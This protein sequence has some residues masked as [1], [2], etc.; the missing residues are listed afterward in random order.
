MA[1]I[2]MFT[3]FP[4]LPPE[5]RDQIWYHALSGPRQPGICQWQPGLWYTKR[6]TAEDHDWSKDDPNNIRLEF[7]YDRLGTRVCIPI[8]DVNQEAHR[9]A[10]AW[11]GDNNIEK[12]SKYGKFKFGRR[13]DKDRDT[14]YFPTDMIEFIETEAV[15]RGFEDDLLDRNH[16]VATY[17]T[18]L[19]V[20][21]RFMRVA[22]EAPYTWD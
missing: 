18:S 19:A 2:K 3:L 10:L 22:P 16:T 14:I 21:E 1:P 15:E 8:A 9:V 13:M 4:R 20:S 7:R 5:L 17:I 11:A 12:V 6:L